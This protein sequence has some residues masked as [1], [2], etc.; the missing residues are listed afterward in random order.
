MWDQII[1][2]IPNFNGA[3]FEVWEMGKVILMG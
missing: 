2:Q 3:T 1:Y